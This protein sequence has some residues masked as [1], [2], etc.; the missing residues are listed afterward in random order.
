[1]C[2]KGSGRRVFHGRPPVPFFAQAAR[3]SATC[4]RPARRV[5]VRAPRACAAC[6][7][8]PPGRRPHPVQCFVPPSER[9]RSRC[10]GSCEGAGAWPSLGV[11]A[12]SRRLRLV[13]G[14]CAF[15]MAS[16]S[17]EGAACK[18]GVAAHFDHAAVVLAHG[19]L[20]HAA[21]DLVAAFLATL[22]APSGEFAALLLVRLGP[23]APAV[24]GAGSRHGGLRLRF[25]GACGGSS[26]DGFGNGRGR[27]NG[28]GS[29]PSP[30]GSGR[31]GSPHFL[32]NRTLLGGGFF[33]C[34]RSL[35]ALR[36]VEVAFLGVRVVEHRLGDH[37]V[38]GLSCGGP[39]G[40]QFLRSQV[41]R[42]VERPLAGGG[43]LQGSGQ[44]L[45]GGLPA[46]DPQAS[47][48]AVRPGARPP[49]GGPACVPAPCAPA[50]CRRCRAGSAGS[51]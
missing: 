10:S 15:G 49:P 28:R 14:M 46:F 38:R 43:A 36:R 22:N 26:V 25:R 6:R 41:E 24:L 17:G 7:M 50:R 3:A 40:G 18:V 1:M 34:C 12:S 44:L 9:P 37:L 21:A 30:F 8:R 23:V 2:G 33:P 11:R 5:R 19:A 29:G 32:G 13:R 51:P 42:L 20:G 16:R 47:A 39:L 27:R 35:L 45:P 4:A 31:S 48:G